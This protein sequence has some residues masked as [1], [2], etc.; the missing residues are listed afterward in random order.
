M[1]ALIRYSDGLVQVVHVQEYELDNG[2]EVELPQTFEVKRPNTG[3]VRVV[4]NR[5]IGAEWQEVPEYVEVK[6]Y[7]GK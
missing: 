2:R 6:K 4:L 1:K 7:G 5:I 3:K